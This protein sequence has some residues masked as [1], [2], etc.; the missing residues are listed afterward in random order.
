AYAPMLLAERGVLPGLQVA[1]TPTY[2]RVND[3]ARS[4][5]HALR[6][7]QRA[8]SARF[9]ASAA[10][11]LVYSA[12]VLSDD[13]LRDEIAQLTEATVQEK[14]SRATEPAAAFEA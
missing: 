5:L 11:A 6:A 7:L 10:L 9:R 14:L 12:G 2:R 13:T 4:H 8:Q 1:S 3:L